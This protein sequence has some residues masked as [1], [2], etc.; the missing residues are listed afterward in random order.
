MRNVL[1]TALCSLMVGVPYVLLIL[2]NINISARLVFVILLQV[3]LLMFLSFGFDAIKSV[4]FKSFF[5]PLEIFLFITIF[6]NIALILIFWIIKWL[7]KF[8]GNKQS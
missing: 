7:K 5:S 2:K 3:C 6:I 4:Y 8:K 1:L